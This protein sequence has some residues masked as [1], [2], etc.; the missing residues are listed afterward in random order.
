MLHHSASFFLLCLPVDATPISG[1]TAGISKIL[2]TRGQCNLEV[3]ALACEVWG[4]NLGLGHDSLELQGAQLG[5]KTLLQAQL[6]PQHCTQARQRN[7]AFV[8]RF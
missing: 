1:S 4:L 7:Y 6:G 2:Y 8:C 5:R 3:S